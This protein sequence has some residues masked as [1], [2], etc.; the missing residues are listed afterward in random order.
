[1]P[2]IGPDT[3]TQAKVAGLAGIALEANRTIVLDLGATLS[4]ADEL[5]LFMVGFDPDPDS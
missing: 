3:M 5:G 1:M 2:A 4:R